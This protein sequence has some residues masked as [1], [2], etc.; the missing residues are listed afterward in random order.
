MSLLL[1][2]LRARQRTN[3]LTSSL[4][5]RP[6]Q[7]QLRVG[8]CAHPFFSRNFRMKNNRKYQPKTVDDLVIAN[9]HTRQ[10]IAEY[11]SG[12]RD[13][14]LI[15]HGPRGT[16]KSTTAQVIV[17]TRCGDPD[18]VSTY[19]GAD[20]TTATFDRILNDWQWQQIN[21]VALPTVIIDEIDQIKPIDQN[22]MRRFVEQHTWG[23][24]IGTT[25][26]QYDMD[27]PLVDRFDSVELPPV[28]VEAWVK[29]AC[30]I[31]TEA[32]VDH[33]P[34]IARRIVATNNGSIRDTRRAIDDYVIAKHNGNQSA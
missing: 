30:E 16:G 19:I 21:G 6:D 11:A 27:K 7:T 25:N 10:R 26:K 29:R 14:N 9:P 3:A 8:L 24:I 4:K 5:K 28:D 12:V 18:L 22:R 15:L 17:E 31:F 13:D 34:E 23:S 32:G 33:T 20:F 2:L 1:R